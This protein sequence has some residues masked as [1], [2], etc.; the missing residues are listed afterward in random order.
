[1]ADLNEKTRIPL[2]WVVSA[3]SAVAAGVWF[4]SALS[5]TASGAAQ[6]VVELRAIVHETNEGFRDMKEIFLIICS[7]DKFCREQLN[8]NKLRGN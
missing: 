6:G 7:R 3:M 5:T 1:M 4:L 8:Q 2:V